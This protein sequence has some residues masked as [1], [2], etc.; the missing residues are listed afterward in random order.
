[1]GNL[2]PSHF[3]EKELDL[4]SCA[5]VLVVVSARYVAS[6]SGSLATSSFPGLTVEEAEP[7]EDISDAKIRSAS[8]AVVEVDPG[9]PRS[10]QRLVRLHRANPATP[11]IAAVP[12]LSV[13]LV[14]TLV[15]EG[16]AD[17]ISLPFASDELLDAALDALASRSAAQVENVKLAPMIAVTRSI[18]GSGA[19]SIATHLAAELARQSGTQREA[20]VADLDLQFGCVADML[21]AHGRGTIADLL[22]TGKLLDDE[23]IHSVARRTEDGVAVISAPDEI[24]PLESIE[25][26]QLLRVLEGLRRNYSHVVLDLPAN[27]TSWTLSAAAAADVVVLVVELTV[28]SLRQAK[29]RLDLFQSVGIPK[30]NIAVVVNRFEKRLFRT[31]GLDDV[32][33]TLR[34]PVAASI[35]LDEPLVN[36]AQDQGRLV[37]GLHRK[38]RFGKGITELAEALL[39]GRIGDR[40]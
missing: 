21:G 15:R 36:S 1:M 12:D 35:P 29:R 5:D 7:W 18:G 40:A 22:D 2:G 31:I 30:E 13:S 20:A 19:T 10:L 39:A 34:H 38:S 32:A 23:L 11:F 26:D 16:V 25:T 14:R 24:V 3:G 33:E 37:T 4:R 6:L 28:Q 27:W 9:D 8:L 17:V